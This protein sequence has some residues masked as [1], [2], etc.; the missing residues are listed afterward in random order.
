MNPETTIN[1]KNLCSR[2]LWELLTEQQNNSRPNDKLAC[3]AELL[4]RRH[5]TAEL[6]RLRSNASVQAH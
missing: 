3:E 5:Y 6:Q 1:V 4:Q 2:K